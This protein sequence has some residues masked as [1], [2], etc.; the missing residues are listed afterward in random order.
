MRWYYPSPYL[1]REPAGPLFGGWWDA[2][3]FVVLAIIFVAGFS[4]MVAMTP[5][6]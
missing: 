6:Y 2:A 5:W 3:L 1:P 4:L